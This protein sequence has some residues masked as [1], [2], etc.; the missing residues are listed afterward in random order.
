MREFLYTSLTLPTFFPVLKVDLI[1]D[2]SL[3]VH[4]LAPPMPKR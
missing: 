2:T 3:V 1:R 4:S